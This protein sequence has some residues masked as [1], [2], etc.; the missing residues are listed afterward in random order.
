MTTR[1]MT[2]RKAA[3]IAALLG[4]TALMTGCVYE[5]P[6]YPTYAQAYPGY[7][8]YGGYYDYPGYYY[9]PTVGLGFGFGDRDDW[10]HGWHGGHHWH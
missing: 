8:Y 5:E 3:L 6:A 9:G 2:I 4:A 10:H 7:G 1:K